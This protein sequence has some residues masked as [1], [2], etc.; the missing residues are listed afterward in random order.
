MT[1]IILGLATLSFAHATEQIQDAQFTA[2]YIRSLSDLENLQFPNLNPIKNTAETLH[3]KES[4]KDLAPLVVIIN[5]APKGTAPDAQKAKVYIDGVLV[6]TFKVSTGKIGFESRVGYFRPV[7]DKVHLRMYEE[8]YS[9]KYGSRMARAIF[10]SGGYAIHHTDAT[11]LLGQ[12]ASSG[13][14]RFTL[15]DI[16]TIHQYALELGNLNYVKRK[17][18]WDQFNGTEKYNIHYKGLAKEIHP[19]DRYT[20]TIDTTQMSNSLDMVIL[21]K[22][23]RSATN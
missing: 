22:D 3:E 14:V 10:Y 4:D 6:H 5:R 2:E 12:R 21:V 13:C 17:W 11:W 9:N 18:T 19:I 23:Q 1:Y 20:G 8:Y 7:H 15:D 16:D